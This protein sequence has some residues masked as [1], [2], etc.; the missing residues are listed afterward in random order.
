[1]LLTSIMISGEGRTV[2]ARRLWRPKH[3]ANPRYMVYVG[4]IP[5]RIVSQLRRIRRTG[6]QNP[7]NKHP[8]IASLQEVGIDFVRLMSISAGSLFSLSPTR[9]SQP[10]EVSTYPFLHLPQ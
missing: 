8:C 9:C 5:K 2:G 4:C 7:A 10:F 6:S 3:P 1:M